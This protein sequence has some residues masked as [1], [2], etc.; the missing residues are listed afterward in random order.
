[1]KLT[2]GEALCLLRAMQI[3]CDESTVSTRPKLNEH[4]QKEVENIGARIVKAMNSGELDE[5][6]DST[7]A[8]SLPRWKGKKIYRLL[9]DIDGPDSGPRMSKGALVEEVSRDADDRLTIRSMLEIT[10]DDGE[11][12]AY[13]KTTVDL[14]D[15]LPISLGKLTYYAWFHLADGRESADRRTV[16]EALRLSGLVASQYMTWTSAQRAEYLARYYGDD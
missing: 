6:E 15:V 9:I 13:S 11:H 12:R 14:T 7:D 16:V 8:Q 1:M 5:D 3:A 10:T 2:R 4:E